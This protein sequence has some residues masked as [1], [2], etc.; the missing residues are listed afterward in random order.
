MIHAVGI[1]SKATKDGKQLT[2]DELLAQFDD[3]NVDSSGQP[4]TGSA[5]GEKKDSAD[6]DVLDELQTLASQR[7][8]SRPSTPSKRTSAATPPR[9]SEEKPTSR[10]SGESSRPYHTSITP[11]ETTATTSEAGITP[12]SSGSQG[13]SNEGGGGGGWW[14]GLFATA[15]AAVKQAEAA[16]QEIRQNEEAQKWADQVRGNVNSL[17]GL[18]MIYGCLTYMLPFD[19]EVVV[20]VLMVVS[21]W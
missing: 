18:G 19:S 8:S 13:N 7:P 10:K 1:M 2:T 15:S 4:K 21:T 6:P 20:L 16:V 3:L 5:G 14:G 12:Q 11:A 17:K 9:S